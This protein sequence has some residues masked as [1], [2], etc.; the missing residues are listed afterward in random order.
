MEY[1]IVKDTD[2]NFNFIDIK[3]NISRFTLNTESINSTLDE[4]NQTINMMEEYLQ[5]INTMEESNITE[6]H[7]YINGVWHDTGST[8]K[9]V[10]THEQ[11]TLLTKDHPE[12]LTYVLNV[13][14]NVS[15]FIEN[16]YVYIYVNYFEE[17][18]EDLLTAYNALI[19]NNG[20]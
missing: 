18:H 16:G 8:I 9:V 15:Y 19:F 13:E 12:L 11:N 17:G 5:I 3:S 6:Y 2:N 1:K 7:P 14:N 4:C 20:V 10:L